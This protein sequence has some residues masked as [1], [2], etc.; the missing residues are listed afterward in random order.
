VRIA[1]QH[2]GAADRTARIEADMFRYLSERL[3]RHGYT[4]SLEK[5]HSLLDGDVSLNT[6]GLEVWLDRA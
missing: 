2:A 6:A 5:R 3:D 4:G 1:R